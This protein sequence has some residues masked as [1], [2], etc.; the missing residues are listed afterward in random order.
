MLASH[1]TL[2]YRR[3]AIELYGTT[4]T[5]NLVGDDWDP[6]GLEVWRED[7][8]AWE[9]REPEDATWLWTDGLREAVLALQSGRAPLDNAALDVH[10]IEVI[11][12]CGT[13]AA[14]TGA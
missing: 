11:A 3:P 2:A 6:H 14:E 9:L 5:A 12:A 1:A 10:L 13:G 7:A 8:H 4:G